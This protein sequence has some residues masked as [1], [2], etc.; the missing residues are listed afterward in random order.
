MVSKTQR[1]PTGF[2]VD[3]ICYIFFNNQSS[4][5]MRTAV[6]LQVSIPEGSKFSS[7]IVPTKDSAR[8]TFLLDT[9]IK[10]NQPVLFVGPTGEPS[11]FHPML[12][13]LHAEYRSI[14]FP[15]FVIA[16]DPKSHI[17]SDRRCPS[18]S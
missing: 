17:R 5:F 10:H 9:A 8:Y 1:F 12:Q 13:L 16:N 3:V 15:V 14:Q 4:L 11:A 18:S 7:I 2:E 6:H